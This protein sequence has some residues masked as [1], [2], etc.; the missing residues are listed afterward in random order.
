MEYYIYITNDCNMNCAYCSV[1]FDT[2]RYGVPLTPQYTYQDLEHF[3]TKTQTELNDETADIYFFGGEPTVACGSIRDLIA[4][5]DGPH[6]YTVNF[7]MHTNGLLIPQMPQ[8]IIE[9]IDVALLSYNYELFFQNEQ[10][11]PYFGQ[12]TAAIERFRSTK[13]FPIIGRITVSPKTSLF[14]ESCLICNFVDYVYWQIDNCAELLEYAAYQKQY[15]YEITLLFKYWMECLNKGIFLRF[16]PF[17][18]AI[19]NQ[20]IEPELPSKFYCGYGHSMIYVQ[21]NGK[22]YACCDNVSTN[23]HL[24]GD[25][26]TGINF[27][28]IDLAQT[29]CGSCPYIKLCGGRCGR[30]HKDFNAERVSQFCELNKYMFNL[31]QTAMPEIRA[32]IE[33]YPEYWDKFMDP[34]IAYT[35]YTA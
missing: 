32:L 1:L 7:I 30:M 2:Q 13:K 22:C 8:Q 20:I 6:N 34:M 26:F 15:K 4:A 25:I 19:K 24:I 18:S 27:P 14:T 35:E 23:S 10:L 33:K 31:T 17:M 3:I 28:E 16:V 9:R 21:T 12:M 11:T 5:M 29:V